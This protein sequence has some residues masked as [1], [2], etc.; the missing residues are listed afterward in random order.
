MKRKYSLIVLFV[1]LTAAMIFI[2]VS[3]D[4]NG[5]DRWC[6]SDEYGCWV[7]DEDGGKC[8]ITFWSE[9]A[10]AYFMGD[11]SK[12]GSLVTVKPNTP[13]GRLT[14]EAAPTRWTWRDFLVEMLTKHGAYLEEHLGG[15]SLQQFI[16]DQ[17]YFFESRLNN[18]DETEDSIMSGLKDWDKQLT[19]EEKTK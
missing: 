11:K 8:Y 10:R 19:K 3:A 2:T 1:L 7:T 6:N 12:P 5:N 13:D 9:E 18:G 17:L 16:S 14:L 15:Y 4:Q